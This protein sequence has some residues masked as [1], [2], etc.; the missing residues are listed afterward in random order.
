MNETCLIEKYL[1]NTLDPKERLLIEA[2]CLVDQELKNKIFWQKQTY[3]LI[4][5]FGRKQLKKDI[6]AAEKQ[7]FSQKHYQSFRK[8]IQSIFNK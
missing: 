4:H 2:Q 5:W 6:S 1:D 3:D 7:I 8:I